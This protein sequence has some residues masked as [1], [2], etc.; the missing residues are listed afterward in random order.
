VIL[1]VGVRYFSC[2]QPEQVKTRLFP[3]NSDSIRFVAWDNSEFNQGED[4]QWVATRFAETMM[5]PDSVLRPV[6]QALARLTTIRVLTSERPDTLGV[7]VGQNVLV[8]F[9]T[10][11]LPDAQMIAIGRSTLYEGKPATWVALPQ[12]S[13]YYLVDG[14]LRSHFQFDMRQFRPNLAFN[15]NFDQ[16]CGAQ[17]MS[18]DQVLFDLQ[19][20]GDSVVMANPPKGFSL[21]MWRMFW[22]TLARGEIATDFSEIQ[23]Q[24]TFWGSIVF[25]GCE[26]RDLQLKFYFLNRF[27]PTEDETQLKALRNFKPHWV[28]TSSQQPGRYFYVE[29]AQMLRWALFTQ[30]STFFNQMNQNNQ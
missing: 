25:K 30:N 17:I 27:E 8:R 14:D 18:G 11:E 3:I 5:V 29:D 15:F 19:Q 2:Q 21:G 20:Q 16:L 4:G 13:Q 9:K 23:A 6:L 26:Q 12:H 10:E 1:A 22:P 24:E 28:M 7:A